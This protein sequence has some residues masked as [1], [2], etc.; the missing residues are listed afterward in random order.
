MDGSSPVSLALHL[1]L[2][3]FIKSLSC[4]ISHAFQIYKDNIIPVKIEI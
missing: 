3:S 2:T 1:H 4:L